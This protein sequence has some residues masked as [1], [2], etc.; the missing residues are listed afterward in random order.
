MFRDGANLW[1]TPS[2]RPGDNKKTQ[3]AQADL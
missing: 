1:V 3:V 2:A